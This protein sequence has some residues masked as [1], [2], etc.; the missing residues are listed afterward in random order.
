MAVKTGYPM[1][2]FEVKA[3]DKI[4]FNIFGNFEILIKVIK[5]IDRANVYKNLNPNCEPFLQ[6]KKRRT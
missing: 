6:K 5:I 1:A 2:A 4:S 3:F